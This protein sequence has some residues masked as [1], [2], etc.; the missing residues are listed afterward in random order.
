MGKKSKSKN[1]SSKDNSIT[2]PLVSI[3][4]PTFN[5]RPFFKGLIQCISE[6]DYPRDKMEWIIADDGTDCVRDILESDDT[7]EKL[8]G[9]KIL[10]F[11]ET[12]KMDLGKKRNYMHKKCSF[13][14]D[15]DIIVYM[16]DDDFYPPQRVSHSVEKL[17]KNPEALAGGASE[18][19]LWFN[20]LNK[21]YKFGPY[22][23]NHATAGTFAFRRKLLKQSSYEDDAALAEE[24]HFLQN[25]TV[26]FV[27]FDPMKTILVVSHEQNTFDKRRLIHSKNAYCKE[28][29]LEVKHFIENKMLI[30]FYDKEINEKLK[31]Y[32]PGD[33]K[34]KP[35][36]LAEIARRD[37]QR[38][39]MHE[40]RPSGIIAVN[41]HNQQK[42]LTIA[43]VKNS[44]QHL[45]KEN[46]FL[47]QKINELMKEQNKLNHIVEEF[48]RKFGIK[49]IIIKEEPR[50]MP[51]NVNPT[52]VNQN[53]VK[54]IMEQTSCS[55]EVAARA[56]SANNGDVVDAIL[57]ISENKEQFE[58]SSTST[59]VNQNDVK[60]IMEQT[61]CSAEVAARALSANNGDVV[62]AILQISEN[63]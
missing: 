57:Q 26:P 9:I 50:T 48:K 15:E 55:A 42:E 13:N 39:A 40:N 56:L 16:D 38:K 25:Y 51:T 44:M 4:T 22:G 6:Q 37:A 47:K 45:T 19:F 30:E 61:S 14:G 18:L 5:R 21:M 33:V 1:K 27:Q 23:P 29:N 53:D 58:T 60:V 43:E 36:V 63:N 49:K 41:Q 59:N 11:H 52:N 10:Y 24:R 8:E 35:R 34:N 62:D 32:E 2:L 54:V 7:K 3:C 12:E 46:M 31:N 28:S 17:M 20:T